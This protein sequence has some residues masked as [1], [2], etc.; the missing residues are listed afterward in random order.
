MKTYLDCFPC[1]VRHALDA[2]RFSSNDEALHRKVLNETM[3]ELIGLPTEVTPPEITARIHRIIKR[4]TGNPDPYQPVKRKY[5][6]IAL[7]MYPELKKKVTTAK[8]PLR[9]AT[10][11]AIAGNIIDFGALGESF[12]LKATISKVLDSGFDIDDYDAFEQ[13]VNHASHILYLGDN[14]GEIVFDKILIEEIK[15]ISNARITFVVKHEPI[16]NDATLTDA[17]FVGMDAV[18]NLITNGYDAPATVLDHVSPEFKQAWETADLVIAKGQ[19]NYE[20]LSDEHQR[21]I[22]FLL[23][24]KCPVL[25]RDIGGRV[26]DTVIKQSFLKKAQPI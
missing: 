18:A 7:A 23:K 24:I 13:A 2:A 11:L 9:M 6:E 1:V 26:G 14:A 25:A 15:R 8:E 12:D 10:R 5:N 17:R 3:Q 20:T 19:G 16:I 21:N 4:V 22:F